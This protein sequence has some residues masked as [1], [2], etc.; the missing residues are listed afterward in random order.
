MSLLNTIN[1]IPEVFRTSPNEAFLGATLDQLATDSVNAPLNGYIG[2]TFSPTYKL[3]DNYIPEINNRRKNYQLEA[4]V[5]VPD[6]NKKP[7]FKATFADL[8]NS[9]ASNGGYT[10][11]QQRLFGAESYNYDG[12]FD[13]DKFVNYYNYYWLPNGPDAISIY[14]ND[15]PYTG[16]YVVTRNTNENGYTFS[17]LGNH[18][19]TQIAL[20]RGGVY[21]FTV[22]QPGINFWIQTE[23]GI[24]GIADFAPTVTTRQVF[25]VTNNGI[26]KGTITFKVPL[27][28]AQD[29]YQNM[30]TA[31]H[32]GILAELYAGS[33][34]I[35]YTDIQNRLLSEFL[36]EFPSGIDGI[37]NLL[38]GKSI[39][40]LGNDLDDTLWT[41]PSVPA[42]FTGL[43]TSE[44]VPGSI[45]SREQR[46]YG[47]RIRLMPIDSQSSDYVIQLHPEIRIDPKEKAFVRSGITNASKYF[48][49]NANYKFVEVPVLT[50]SMDYLYYQDSENENYF[51][52]IKIVDNNA[53]PINVTTDILGKIGYT[54]PNGVIFTNGLKVRFDT[55]VVPSSYGNKEYYVEGVGT[56]I[57]LVPVDQLIIPESFG[58][59]IDV[60]PDFMTIN[61]ASLDRNPWSR[62]NRWFHKDVLLATAKYNNTLIDYTGTIPA[63]R[64]II[65]FN[66]NLGLYNTGTNA[67]ENVDVVIFE[68]TDAFNEIEGHQ[69]ATVDGVHLSTGTTIV[70]A[71]DYD[72]NV[73]N[74][75]WRVVVENIN[76]VNFI[77]L[78]DTGTSVPTGTNVLA[79][80][81]G[82]QGNMYYFDGTIWHLCQV[83]ESVNQAPLFD[84]FDKDGYSFSNTT[85]YPN[86]TFAGTKIFG[87]KIGTGTILDSVLGLP[88][89]FQNFNNIGDIVFTN[90]FDTDTFTYSDGTLEIN[91]GYLK[92]TNETSSKLET[93]WVTCVEPT[94]QYQVFTKFYD[95]HV[96]EI[97]G[98]ERAFVQIDV[99]PASTQTTTPYCKVYVNNVLLTNGTQYN[100]IPY[101]IYHI[102]ELMDTLTVG[103]KIDVLIY[104]NEV[105]S[106][107]YYEVPR[108]LDLNP[109]NENFP[110]ITLGQLRTHYN[111]LVE[112]YSG[113]RPTQDV[114]LKAQAGT[115]TTHSSPAIYAAM[116]LNDSKVNFVAGIELARKEYTRFKNKFLTLASTLTNLNYN[117]PISSVDTILQSINVVKN[118]SFPWYYSDMVPQG[119]NYTTITYN[120]VNAR[121]IQYEINTI[122]DNTVLSNRAVIVYHNGVQ[123]THGVDYTFNQFAPSIAITK[124]M[125][126]GDVIVIRDYFDT[127]GNYVPE[128]PTKLG[129][130]PK[131]VP[132]IYL[133]DT[134]QTPVNMIRGHD[135]SLTP[136]FGDFRDNFLLELERR[137]YNNI[138]TDYSANELDI[139]SIVPGRFRDTSYNLDE[140]TKLL[141]GNFLQ[142][143]GS[144]TV[145]FSTN[146]WFVQNNPWTW[147]YS[148]LQDTI[149]KSALT[150]SWRAIYKYWFDTDRPHIAPWEMLGFTS[151]PSWWL[152][153][154]GEAPYT[155]GNSTMWEDLEAGYVWNNGSPY[156]NPNFVRPGLIGFIPVDEYGNLLSPD[157]IPLTKEVTSRVI[158]S[159]FAIGHY[160]PVENAWRNSS[161]FPFAVQYAF[162]L[163]KPAQFFATQ[164]DTS[165]FGRNAITNH[166]STVD[167][168]KITPSILNVNGDATTGTI[169]RTSG[170]INWVADNIKNLGIN[171]I[172]VINDYFS[173]LTVQLAY[174]VGG[175][176]DKKLITVS[177]EQTTPTSTNA[178]IIIPDENYQVFLGKS[179]PVTTAVYSAVV[180]EQTVNGYIVTGYDLTNPFF[181]VYPSIINGNYST[182]KV[183]DLGAKLYVDFEKSPMSIPYGTEFTTVTQVVDF[184]ISYQRY[185]DVQG[186]ILN[187]YDTDLSAQR[188][189]VLSSQEFL[190][191]A[192]Q[193][194]AIGTIILLNPITSKIKFKST[195]TFV[196]EISNESRGSRILDQNFTPIKSN[197]FTILRNTYYDPNSPVPVNTCVLEIVNGTTVCYAKFNLVQYE[198]TLIFD[199][200]DDFGDIIYVPK[201]GTRQNR[202][203]ISGQ[204]TGGWS[205]MLSAPGY[206]YSD[207][208]VTTWQ[209]N[210]DYKI[211]DII[212]F[213]SNYYVAPKNV[214]ANAKFDVSLWT[215][216][217][218]E[219]LRTG[220]LPSFGHN[221]QK[222]T[223]LYD[224]DKPPQEEDLQLFSGGLI[225]FR[226]KPYLTDLGISVPNQTKFYQG[227]I[228]QKGSKNSILSLTKANFENVQSTVTTYE[229]WAF[230][231]GQY[232]DFTRNQYREFELDQSLFTT[233]PVAFTYADTAST[234]N[235][236]VN[237]SFGNIY[238]SSN[239]S[240]VSTELYSNRETADYMA[241]LPTAGFVNL[242]DVESLIYDITKATPNDVLSVGNGHKIWTAIDGNGNWNVLRVS[243]T[244]LIATSVAYVSGSYAQ[245]FFNGAHTF[246][247]GDTFVLNSFN[248]TYGNYNG[249]YTV[250]SVPN[251]SSVVIY[252]DPTGG[253]NLLYLVQNSPLTAAGTVYSLDS[254]V[255]DQVTDLLDIEPIGGWHQ[256]DKVWV[257]NATVNGWGVYTYKDAWPAN[258]AQELTAITPA[259]G[260]VFG[261]VVRISDDHSH[262]FVGVP[263]AGKV[264]VFTNTSS[265]TWSITNSIYK[266]DVD[267]GAAIETRNGLLS[268]GAPGSGT[269][270]VY[271][272]TTDT[273][274][275]NPQ[276][277][278]SANL[279]GKFGSS[280]AFSIDCHWMFVGEPGSNAVQAYY[281]SNTN[282]ANVHYT[283]V[284]TIG[285]GT[286]NVGS[287]VKTNID[288]TVIFVS[289]PDAFNEYDH[290]GNVQIY[291]RT[292]N[293]F[294]HTQTISSQFKN[295][296]ANFGADIDCDKQAGNLFVGVPGSTQS[297]SLTGRVERYVFNGTNYEFNEL[298]EHPYEGVGHFGSVV[299]ASE[300]AQALVIG[301]RGSSSLEET[302]FDVSSTTIDGGIIFVDA[303]FNSGAVY[304]FEPLIN[305]TIPG[306][307]GQYIY[308]QDL[309]AQVYP[310]DRFGDS[311]DTKRDIMVI[312]A[313]GTNNSAGVVYVYENP[314][315][316]Y[317]WKLTQEQQPVVDINSI[318][319]TFMYD[320][321]TNSI[322]A[323]LD[324]IDPAKGKL[325]SVIDRDID[326]KKQSD[327]AVY[328]AGKKVE[329]HVDLHW[330][331]QQVGK[332][333]WD[334]DTV[335]FV[336]Y[337]QS[338]LTYRLHNWGKMFPGSK[339][340]VFQWIESRVLPSQ[341]IAEGLPGLP[342]HRDDSAYCTNT[343]VDKSG[344]IQLKYYYWVTNTSDVYPGKTNSVISVAAAIENPQS[345]GIPYATVLRNDTLA[346]YNVNSLLTGKNTVVHVGKRNVDAG[347]IH[348]EYALVQ[349]GNPTSKI[350]S[351]LLNKLVD[352]LSGEDAS[353]NI[354]PDS[355]LTPAQ[356]YG[357]SVSPRQSMFIDRE[358]ALS[359][360]FDVV[361][362]MM[363]AY[364]VA[365]RKVLTG[366]NSSEEAPLMESGAYDMSVNSYAELTYIR[367]HDSEGSLV[368]PFNVDGY[369]VLVTSDETNNTKWGIYTWSEASGWTRTQSQGYKTNLYW[370]YVDWYDSSFN[371]SQ[372]VDY[373]VANNLDFGKLTLVANTYVKILDSGNSNFAIYYI[374]SDLNKSLVGIQGGTVQISTGV[375]PA[376]ELRQILTAIQTQILIDDLAAEFNQVF[377]LLVKYA[378]TEQKNLD[379]VFKTS[380]LSATQYIRKLEPFPAYIPD[381]QNYYLEYINEVKPYRTILREFVVDY[382]GSDTYGSDVT[383]FDI[384]PYWDNTMSVY[385]SP[386]GE[387][388]GDA[389]MLANTS[390]YSQWNTNYTYGVT[391]IIVNPIGIG[392]VE[393]PQIIISGGGGTG[394]KATSEIWG[395]GAIKH[396]TITASGTGYTSQ[397]DVIING[398]GTGAKAYAILRNVFDSNNKGHNVVRSINTTMKFDRINY[399]QANTFVFWDTITSANIG[400]SID[401]GT[402]L[403][404]NS[405]LYELDDTYTIDTEVSFP[406]SNVTEINSS[407]FDNANDRIIAN[408]GFVNLA[409]LQDG[410]DYPGVKVDGN[411]FVGDTYDS[412]ISSRY[413]SSI[414]V[415]P[416]DI[417][418][419]GGAYY[420]EYNSHAPQ[421]LVPGI[422][423]DNLNVQVFDTNR[424]A[425]RI[426]QNMQSAEIYCRI[427]ESASS[428]LSANLNIT[429]ETI[430]VE[431]AS[432][433]PEPNPALGI[434]GEVHVNGEKI[435]YYT[436]DVDSNTLGQLRRAVD[437][438]GAPLVHVTGTR[439]VDCSL[440]QHFPE[441]E[442]TKT[443]ASNDTTY[444]TSANVSFIVTTSANITA[445][446]GDF[447]TQ[448]NVLG[449]VRVLES[450]TNSNKIP[451]VFINQQW[452]TERLYING[453]PTTIDAVS[454]SPIGEINANGNVIIS[455]GTTLG[456]SHTWYKQGVNTPADG[457]GI[458]GTDNLY[459][460]FLKAEL[461]YTP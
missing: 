405:K 441:I 266:T 207:P 67:I 438:T 11:N 382:V 437:G 381:N 434:P 309:Q 176:T 9:I 260:T 86:S 218:L 162:A 163:A 413:T 446:V 256:N 338:D 329:H 342:L 169:K 88:L 343:W 432:A 360:Y 408:K 177:A 331:P 107:G 213:N 435:Y 237:L 15:V 359:N 72:I 280:I 151:R 290:N 182:I 5:V 356:A 307:I 173:N 274:F 386:N 409:T 94:E 369:K 153:R 179:N 391:D 75:I 340:L 82:N 51:G 376:K 352:S 330:G 248:T 325:L 269:V 146:K 229:E 4:T 223:N 301:S 315:S 262:V 14:S 401:A 22:D 259:P 387:Q 320:K 251:S 17:T 50:S 178:S 293:V 24:D 168:K 180:V 460:Q 81:G 318:N 138:K 336:D 106:L 276:L 300:D 108:N 85:V 337:E 231:V 32:D 48:W 68:E 28:S 55:N 246:N 113:A 205:G 228:K 143:A 393:P 123:L 365:E 286:G 1:L 390:A 388:P 400:D 132:E 350:P 59:N 452:T 404:L 284:S 95:G 298:I 299:S 202:L 303:V 279:N 335:R 74:K 459:T 230:L 125:A 291:T 53:V 40:F 124:Q 265:N 292:G 39:I 370:S 440:D 368:E 410:I 263:D 60:D 92:F 384:Q 403:V 275:T 428:V 310:Y 392:F 184:L 135:G 407:I 145:D 21:T 90:Y 348:N 155:S 71:N 16:N 389:T 148:G 254:M 333:W 206:I 378:L 306:S 422:V 19:N 341:H 245:L 383:D 358:L 150:G 242:N 305:R 156:T 442:F 144:N 186:F 109:L 129:L 233:N 61:R 96:V 448:A 141:S 158:S 419:D 204:K 232:G 70:F 115:I 121:Q 324:Y 339:V 313:P 314:N 449:N 271:K 18:P 49:V 175:F 234:G 255:I 354:V 130:Y 44:V 73:K 249:V 98:V 131:S 159:N 217:S 344:N 112:N 316:D 406:V 25:G 139:Y 62:Y 227:Y 345:Q 272:H 63:R 127:D 103:D 13:F 221:A 100:I 457:N 414:G 35:K 285:S 431:D 192:Q 58:A 395:N 137:I 30:P 302:T 423:F 322:L 349:E 236:V 142:W 267:F 97:N 328:N 174:K 461:G 270:R 167:N 160:G 380:F 424:V 185:L 402:I 308:A 351:F 47:W 399:K 57:T 215:Q 136:A 117:D 374:D 451:V 10:N 283:R 257:N 450:V 36:A 239:L 65:E 78:V 116:F 31:E 244:E 235:L 118:S 183:G 134:Y 317:V 375:I 394:A 458:E 152:D 433:F 361:N 87:Y 347:Q 126:V 189:F 194:W 37:N 371:P 226:Q 195:Y 76:S 367:T 418:I 363:L 99:L 362:K 240:S 353:G 110:I 429:D 220:L 396:I 443:V 77:T 326:Y 198:H 208:K 171:P 119:G 278:T 214:P 430:S 297:G 188:D 41:T 104:G 436:R 140:F 304:L 149:D 355:S 225:G 264:H 332:I 102:V 128:T 193:G 46:V 42:S 281:T 377:F 187:D 26:D 133:D 83:K 321:T 366:L 79:L 211:G 200:V 23:P 216:I 210:H 444:T 199:N 312:G 238:N 364:P 64:P 295:A 80:Q 54:S 372:T 261:S 385:R 12:K 415:A 84:I 69:T 111:K 252:I 89:V 397:P 212:T 147:N 421:E 191:W 181:T 6:V 456:S 287:V 101:G 157:V 154:Y 190:Y 268:V 288:G 165:K 164:I 224:V 411:T 170:Y 425:F 282:I 161:D 197:G 3:G 455:A 222:F 219:D 447:I 417:I 7:K 45:I 247:S 277:I 250:E 357:V 258:T 346:L 319:R 29:F 426:E 196:D 66:A 427:A 203:K 398:T 20:A 43:D 273:T 416:A 294:T 412:Y 420:D 334:I 56:G 93:T 8:L 166:Y 2:R 52:Q 379:W 373:T 327:P 445:N 439:V 243:Q 253:N 27:P 241:D 323:S 289:A 91:S 34:S 38:D 114:Y 201:Q 105:S 454:Y 296:N 120:V 311:I 453:V 122:F 33:T 209:T 172:E